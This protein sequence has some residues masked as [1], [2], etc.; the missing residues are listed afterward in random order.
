M[1]SD[2]H[3]VLKRGRIRKGR[4]AS[5]ESSGLTGLFLLSPPASLYGE[6]DPGKGRIAV[7]ATDPASMDRGDFMTAEEAAWE[8]VSVSVKGL[9][10]TPTWEEMAWVKR[11]FWLPTETVI[12]Y[13]PPEAEYVNNTE[14]L[15]LW[16]RVGQDVDRPPASLIGLVIPCRLGAYV[17]RDAAALRSLVA[18][19]E[20]AG[21]AR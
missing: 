3:P 4:M 20:V 6:D 21:H 8:H 15:H 19:P 13:H 1:R 14:A 11:L 16:R 10:R 7:I 5:D 2:V 9:G 18:R 12:E 17:P